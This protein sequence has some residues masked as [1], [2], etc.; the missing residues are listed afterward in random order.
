MKIMKKLSKVLALMMVAAMVLS[1]GMGAFASGEASGE[2]APGSAPP[3]PP[4]AMAQNVEDMKNTAAISVIDGVVE[5]D[6]TA[7]TGTVT[8][9][10]ISGVMASYDGIGDW[11]GSL[12]FGHFGAVLSGTDEKEFVIGGKE[13]LY[14]VDGQSYNSAFILNAEDKDEPNALGGSETRDYKDAQEGAEGAGI[15]ADMPNLLLDNVYIST[16]GYGRSALHLTADVQDTVVRD[17]AIIATGSE[18]EDSSAPGIIM[19]YASSRPVL[20]EASG[21]TYFYNSDLISSDWG[22]YSLDG[23]YGA[24]IYIV[25]CYSENTVGGYSMYALGFN[26]PNTCWFYGSYAASAQYGT[27]LCAAGRTYTGALADAP[28]AALA[29]L[30]GSD[31]GDTTLLNGWS[32]IGGYTNAVTMQA[33]MSGAE[34]VGVFDAKHTIF[35]TLAV[36]DRNGEPMAD[37]MDLYDYKNDMGVGAAHYFLSYIHGAAFGIRSENVDL[38]LDDCQVFTSNNVAIQTVIGYDN[39]ASNI[40]VPDGTEYYGVNVRVKDMDLNGDILHEDYQRKMIL[41]LENADLCGAVVSGTH[42]AWEKNISDHIDAEWTSYDE[43]LGHTKEAIFDALS[44]NDAYETVWGVRMSIDAD[45]AW[46]VTGDS[47]LYS[48]TVAEGAEII[49]PA[50]RELEIYV[51]CQMKGTDTFYDHTT[52]TQV[53]NLPAGE[54]SGVVILVK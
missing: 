53:E 29:R 51:D 23:C 14:E 3:P 21:N 25:D 41:S 30:D 20:I 40:K 31:L 35:D 37:T 10:G 1:L 16:V 49:A 11:D 26:D 7:M 22:V 45:S 34:I 19:M 43:E 4:S 17:S 18:G 42:A 52:G 47:S 2:A 8:T 6:D 27:I 54:Y 15:Y 9:E 12:A 46:T 48:L 38:I 5:T 33:D 32:Y 44:Y 13:D 28:E 24:N 50:G 36:L 39:M